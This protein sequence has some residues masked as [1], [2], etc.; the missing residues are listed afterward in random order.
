[1][2]D[3]LFAGGVSTPSRLR[4]GWIVPIEFHGEGRAR[5]RLQHTREHNGQPD[6]LAWADVT[7]IS[8]GTQQPKAAINAGD[9]TVGGVLVDWIEGPTKVYYR[10]FRAEWIRVV[11]HDEADEEAVAQCGAFSVYMEPSHA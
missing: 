7:R 8:D 10:R 1:M 11:P 3:I 4:G 6:D 9:S 2:T 5:F